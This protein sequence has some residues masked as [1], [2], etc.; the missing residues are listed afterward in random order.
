MTRKWSCSTPVGRRGAGRVADG[1]QRPSGGAEAAGDA[2]GAAGHPGRPHGK[3]VWNSL[4]IDAVVKRLAAGGM[5]ISPELRAH[6]SPLQWEHI[7]FV[8]SY[9]F[10]RPERPGWLRERRAVS[11]RAPSGLR[12]S[13]R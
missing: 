13:G 8:G 5:K 1:D 10:N 3:K 11:T 12:R 7:N 9:P 4:Y 6:L 2:A